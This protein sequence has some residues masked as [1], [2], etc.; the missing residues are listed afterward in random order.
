MFFSAG[1]PRDCELIFNCGINDILVSYYY[2]RKRKKVFEEDIMVRCK[3]QGGLFMADSGGHSFLSTKEIPD[4]MYYEKYWI[5][6]LEEYVDWLR[7][8]HEYIYVAANMDLEDFVGTAVVDKWNKKYF[9]PLEKLMNIVYVAHQDNIPGD[10]TGLKRFKQYCKL[11]DYVGVNNDLYKY[12]EKFFEIARITKTRIHGF[13]WTSIPTLKQWPFFSVDS[14]TWLGGARYGT[15]YLYD[16]KNFYVKDFKNKHIRRT[17]KIY[18][19]DHKIDYRGVIA[20][21]QDA[22]NTLNLHGWKGARREFIRA[23][24]IKLKT[25]PVLSYAKS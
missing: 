15:T 25:N 9:K 21:K 14:T 13:G 20:D 4:E 23:A 1:S 18:C 2:L 24:N 11:H 19:R 10:K 12:S 3:K 6:F 22:V 17:R 16:G 8:H 5:E 7:E